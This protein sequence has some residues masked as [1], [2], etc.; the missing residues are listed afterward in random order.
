MDKWA[1]CPVV[2]LSALRR[3]VFS[4]KKFFIFFA[5]IFDWKNLSIPRPWNT[6][7]AHSHCKMDHKSVHMWI[8]GRP[9]LEWSNHG[10]NANKIAQLHSGNSADACCRHLVP[11]TQLWLALGRLNSKLARKTGKMRKNICNLIINQLLFKELTTFLNSKVINL[12]KNMQKK[13][14]LFLPTWC[15][16]EFFE[17]FGFHLWSWRFWCPSFSYFVT[18]LQFQNSTWNQFC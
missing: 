18:Q 7:S 6:I 14:R 4:A 17:Y 13:K 5:E 15:I 11:A 12:V 16:I 3:K 9:G 10:L 2:C 8:F 1:L